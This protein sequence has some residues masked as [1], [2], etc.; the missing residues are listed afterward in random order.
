MDS[1]YNPNGT[2]VF[3]G[4]DLQTVCLDIQFKIWNGD[5]IQT[6]FVHYMKDSNCKNIME[7]LVLVKHKKKV[8]VFVNIL[9]Y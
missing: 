5:H 6:H 3:M 8:V 2:R 4:M 1:G 7:E 9:P